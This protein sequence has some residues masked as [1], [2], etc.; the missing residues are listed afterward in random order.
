MTSELTTV[1]EHFA[2]KIALVVDDGPIE[3]LAG[4]SM[5]QKMGLAS[6]VAASGEEALRMLQAQRVD[7]VVCDISMPGMSGLEVLDAARGLSP[8]PQFVMVSS[9]DDEGHARS[10]LERG[11][12][13]YLVKPLRFD[14]LRDTLSEVLSPRGA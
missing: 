10:S 14:M 4:K 9:H 3:R 12:A 1:P 8:A 13:A 5:L 7:V 11:A 2:G 6:L